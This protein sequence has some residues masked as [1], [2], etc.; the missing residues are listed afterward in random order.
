VV[1]YGL[2]KYDLQHFL[3]E[4]REW[5]QK[6][7]KIVK[8]NSEEKNTL[9]TQIQFSLTG[10]IW[11]VNRVSALGRTKLMERPDKTLIFIGE[12]HD[13][14]HSKL[15]LKKWLRKKAREILVP[16]LLKLSVET[17]LTVNKISIREQKSRWG[18]CSSQGDIALNCKLIFLPLPLVRYV[19]IHELCHRLHFNHSKRFW[20]LVAK[21][22]P[23]YPRH[24]REIRLHSQKA[25]FWGHDGV[26]IN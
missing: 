14:L 22:D 25:S 21:F 20:A 6:K 9:P 24:R 13:L 3:S 10:E 26:A 15:L 19:L 12:D 18:S 11:R 2:K 8:L 4:H 7:L 1:P 16:M 5:I 17:G 23:Q